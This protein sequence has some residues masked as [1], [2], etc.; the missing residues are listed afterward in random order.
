V[1]MARGRKE[2]KFVWGGA[3]SERWK[4]I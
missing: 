4:I 1:W 2:L 3:G